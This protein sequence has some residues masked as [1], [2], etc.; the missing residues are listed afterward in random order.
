MGLSFLWASDDGTVVSSCESPGKRWAF[1]PLK[2][3]RP[4]SA[5]KQTM[6]CTSVG[7]VTSFCFLLA[8]FLLT[9]DKATF[10][11]KNGDSWVEL[12]L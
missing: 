6:P 12:I 4:F 10:L 7:N 11:N 8:S 3:R 1:L 9:Y 5:W 2:G